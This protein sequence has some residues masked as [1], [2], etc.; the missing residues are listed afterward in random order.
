VW[1]PRRDSLRGGTGTGERREERV[2]KGMVLSVDAASG[3]ALISADDGARYSFGVADW[4]E[5][6][7]PVRGQR[8]DFVAADGQR[9][10]AVYLDPGSIGSTPGA[11]SSGPS[12][13]QW[14]A[15][16]D[17]RY[18]GLYCSSDDKIL[19]GFCGGIAH[20]F[21]LDVGYVRA[22][23]FLLGFFVIWLP[24]LLGFFLPRLPTK[25]VPR[26]S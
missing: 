4:K 8:V 16:L 6:Q 24:Y 15:G 21:G 13:P 25:G 26:P 23:M 5:K 11:W 9:A 3:Q 17:E 1:R 7:P 10:T 18:R 22:G 2:M 20:K 14:P 12:T 19:I